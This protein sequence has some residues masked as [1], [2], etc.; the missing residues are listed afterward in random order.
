MM[1]NPFR[2]RAFAHELIERQW[3]SVVRN[4]RWWVLPAGLAILPL[5]SVLITVASRGWANLARYIAEGTSPL[6]RIMGGDYLAFA[7]ADMA[8]VLWM[9]GWRRRWGRVR[10]LRAVPFSHAEHESL[11]TAGVLVPWQ[12]SLVG[13]M[14]FDT[15]LSFFAF[16]T[17]VGTGTSGGGEGAMALACLPVVAVF[18]YAGIRLAFAM[19]APAM[20]PETNPAK[21]T[22]GIVLQQAIIVAVLTVAGVASAIGMYMLQL[23]VAPYSSSLVPAVFLPTAVIALAKWKIGSWYWRRF[24]RRLGAYLDADAEA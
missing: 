14:A 1:R 11:L 3:D 17:V 10:E 4:W 20:L 7:A 5:L 16:L 6:G 9:V 19:M 24:S 8:A 18:H 23:K 2:P 12:V 15:V 13:L 21:F 22:M